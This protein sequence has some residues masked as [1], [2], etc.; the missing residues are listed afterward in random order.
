MPLLVIVS[1]LFM[2]LA[3]AG[4]FH[5]QNADLHGKQPACAICLHGNHLA[6][7]PAIV[8]ASATYLA[9]V[10]LQPPTTA[11]RAYLTSAVYYARGP[12]QS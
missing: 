6:S 8:H 1:V 11:D 3:Q 9:S 12:P 10:N 5:K 2:G 7:P 4:H